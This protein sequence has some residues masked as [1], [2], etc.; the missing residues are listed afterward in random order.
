MYV[1]TG[2]NV[3]DGIDLVTR[4]NSNVF[5]S[6]ST[7]SEISDRPP[8]PDDGQVIDCGGRTLMPGLIDAHIHA[9]ASQ[10]NLIQNDLEPITFVAQHAGAMLRSMLDRGFT[11]ARDC[12]GAD[13]GLVKALEEQRLAGP[14]L[15]ICGKLLSQ[16]GGHGDFRHP[17]TA[18]SDDDGYMTCGCGHIGHMSITA[19]G[20]DGVTRAVRENFRRGA[21]FIKFAGSGGVGSMTGS[22][23]ALQYSDAEVIAI[24]AEA[25]RHERYCTAHVH[26]DQ[27]IQRCIA[28]GVHCIEHAT[29]IASDTARRAADHGTWLV[30]TLSIAFSLRDRGAELGVTRASLDK[31]DAIIGGAMTCLGHMREAGCRIGFG[32]DLLGTL[33]QDQCRE[34]S[35]RSEVFTSTEILRQATSGNAVLLR[36]EGDIG[37][38][39]IGARADILVVDG[40]PLRDLSLFRSDGSGLSLIM[41]GGRIHR[42]RLTNDR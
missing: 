40:D 20:V 36:R 30:P 33:E 22:V 42:N 15:S 27:G 25:E 31:L 18:C 23:T 16:S 7:I 17:R 3:F 35:L 26:P 19:D 28:L 5:V 38:I 34:F 12:G 14:S 13:F 2:A 41:Q 9:Y 10:T 1:F 24:V 4:R 21:E 8:T 37:T 11:S 39:A 6:K 29:L 32:T